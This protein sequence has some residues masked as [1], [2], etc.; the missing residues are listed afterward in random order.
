MLGTYSIISPVRN[1][2]EYLSRTIASVV[3]QE[4]RPVEWVIVDDGS[5][6]E[7]AQIA[8]AAAAQHWWIKVIRRQ[9]RGFRQPGQGVVEAFYAGYE[10]LTYKTPDFICKM[11]GDL[12]FKADYFLT[13]LREFARRPRLGMASGATY[14]QKADGKLVQ[15]KVARNFVV[16]PIKL[17]R[18]ACLEDIGGL[19]PHLGWDT[20]DVYRSRMRGW[21]TE[22]YPELKVVHLRQMGAAKGIVWGK[23][24]TGMGEYYY[25]SHPLFVV[26]R[27]LYRMTEKPYGLIGLSIGLGYL[28]ALV[29]REPRI[30]DPQFV[31]FLRADQLARLK[32][33]FMPWK[34]WF[35]IEA[36]T[37]GDVIALANASRV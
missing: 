9:N 11:D 1:E 23:M 36:K 2:A 14:L 8:E 13:L 32:R 29:R 4:H 6:D 5:T 16:G 21:E 7:T 28:L 12:E 3:K 20:I 34:R 24:K 15:E 10:R 30:N 31:K 27:C 22:N 18:R 26:A 33:M 17:Y 35:A 19:E 37:F 25:G